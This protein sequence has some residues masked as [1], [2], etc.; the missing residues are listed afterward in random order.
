MVKG[1]RIAGKNCRTEFTEKK[2]RFI[3]T[4]KRVKTAEEAAEFVHS[5]RREYPDATHHCVAFRLHDPFTERFNDDGEPGGTAGMPML[6][7]LKKNDLYDTALVVTRYFGGILLGAGGLVRAYSRGAAE[8]VAAAGVQTMLPAA[9][10]RLLCAYP[11]LE[12]L[13][14]LCGRFGGEDLQTEY[15]ETVMMTLILRDEA[16]S[17]FFAEVA[18]S[19]AGT[20]VCTL[21]ERLLYGFDAF[22]GHQ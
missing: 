21:T 17:P 8:T 20:A 18:N 2:S 13:Q 6:D 16:V 7:V 5:V 11:H 12:P 1:Y 14:R 9:R 10:I 3:T 4:L 22:T 15:G 19:T